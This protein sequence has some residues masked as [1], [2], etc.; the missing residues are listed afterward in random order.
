MIEK[1]IVDR[2][3]SNPGRITLEPVEG[4][5][6]TYD[7]SRADN[8]E[9]AGTPIN[10]A[11]LDSIIQSRLTGR[12]YT[13]TAT[14]TQVGTLE[15]ITTTPIPISGWTNNGLGLSVN[16][17]YRAMASSGD[18]NYP[19]YAFDG[20]E[21]TAWVGQS[22]TEQWL[23]IELPSAI[24]LYQFILDFDT[25]DM[26]ANPTVTVEGSNNGV[27]WNELLSFDAAQSALVYE[28]SS[29]GLYMFYRLRFSLEHASVIEV[30]NWEFVEYSTPT[31]ENRFL[32]DGFPAS[33]TIG[34][35]ATIQSPSD[36]NTMGVVSNTVNG[37]TC[38]T[39]LQPNKRYELRYNG[40]AFDVKEV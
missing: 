18:E 27:G 13:A 37:I 20:N 26:T 32:V 35:R 39:I 7:M 23:E 9:V 30:Y 3:P 22:S 36:V 1:E 38:N 5:E 25:N 14:T 31:F 15:G 16:G 2:V 28:L 17:L 29:P 24:T 6:N 10:K 11:T 19:F 12:Y 34:Q 21:N 40:A 4:L 8:P 33:W